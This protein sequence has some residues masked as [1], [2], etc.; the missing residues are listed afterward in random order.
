MDLGITPHNI[1]VFGVDLCIHD[2]LEHMIIMFDVSPFCYEERCL[3]LFRSCVQSEAK[4]VRCDVASHM[5]KNLS[6][7]LTA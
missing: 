3:Y 7:F 5:L 2:R 4:Y 6:R 1:M